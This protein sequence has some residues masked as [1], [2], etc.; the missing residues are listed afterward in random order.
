MKIKRFNE[1]KNSSEKLKVTELYV[2]YVEADEE[3]YPR[4]VIKTNNG[5][6]FYKRIKDSY[7]EDD[8]DYDGEQ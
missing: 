5:R 8:L 4:L 7:W 1:K 2:D 3:N 6:T